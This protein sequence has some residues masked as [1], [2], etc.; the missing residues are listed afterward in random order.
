MD[1]F[2]SHSGVNIY[3]A[4]NRVEMGEEGDEWQWEESHWTPRFLVCTTG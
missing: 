4:W 2:K 1:G 3:S